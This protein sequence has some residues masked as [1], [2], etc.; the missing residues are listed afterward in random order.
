MAQQFS[1]LHT[2][3]QS[4][5][6]PTCIC[7]KSLAE[8]AEKGCLRCA[9]NLGGVAPMI[10]LTGSVAVYQWKTGAMAAAAQKGIKAGIATAIDVLKK[11]LGLE[12]LYGYPVQKIITAKT[13]DK[14][15]FFVEGVMMKYNSIE[16]T[17]ET[18]GEN[19]V[20][21]F[22]KDIPRINPVIAVT[23]NA[24]TV[25]IKAGEECAK[26]TA[27]EILSAETASIKLYTAIAYSVTAVLVIVLVMV[28][29]YLILR[30]RRKKKMKKKL[31]YIK[32]LKE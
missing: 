11:N 10:G 7:E 22:Y 25:A 4:D 26:I 15:M 3:I 5:A 9:Q 29:I 8:K 17:L 28:I 12:T 13:F 2:D 23:Q 18:T 31:Q 14:P 19:S 16:C 27:E 6:I 24:R 20:L 32:L 21:C 1:T 30:Y